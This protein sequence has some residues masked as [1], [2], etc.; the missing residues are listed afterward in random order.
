MSYLI[1]TLSHLEQTLSDEFVAKF[2]SE[3]KDQLLRRL[4]T[5]TERDLKDVDKDEV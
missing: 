5:T 3:T 2:T 4:M 1:L